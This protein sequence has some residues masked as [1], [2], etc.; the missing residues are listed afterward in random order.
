MTY[1]STGELAKRLEVSVRTLRYYDQIGLVQPTERGNGGKRLYTEDDIFTLEKILILKDLSLSLED[2]KQI[3]QEQS[4]AS[5]LSA[6]RSSLTEQV[7][8][9]DESIRHTTSLIH[10]LELEGEIKWQ[11]LLTLV[12]DY[13]KEKNWASY[14]T[15]EEQQLL[16]MQLP[17]LESQNIS[18]KKWMNLI[19]RIEL[20]I[21]NGASP[22]SEE[23]QIIMDDM[24]ILSEET[25][26]GDQEL[27]DKFWEVRKSEEASA[28]LRLYPIRQEIIDFIEQ[29]LSV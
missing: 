7:E 23:A 2:S 14:F 24:N 11:D 27:M 16:E 6:H 1:L 22:N 13:K 20:C 26:H 18:T 3:I 8:T 10:V 28:E 4:M 19:K 21:K 5:I 25:F 12:V 9:L 17:S 15:D 29:A